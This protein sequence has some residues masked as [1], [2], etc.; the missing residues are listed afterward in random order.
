MIN[1][2][3]NAGVAVAFSPRLR[4]L[5]GEVARRAE[6][7]AETF[8]LIHVGACTPD[9]EA[10]L[11]DALLEAGLPEDLPIHWAEGAPHDAIIGTVERHQ[12]D[13]LLAGAIEREKTLRYFMGSVAHNLVREAPCSL[14]LFT[15]PRPQPEPMRQVALVTEIMRPKTPSSSTSSSPSL[16]PWPLSHPNRPPA[17]ISG[18]DGPQ[19]ALLEPLMPFQHPVSA[20]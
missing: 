12:L 13:L 11:K 7:L 16:S 15:E 8:S 6:Y 18:L 3:Q 4:G 1:L 10:R 19:A 9:K 20:L 2:Y 14:V 17:G 5:L